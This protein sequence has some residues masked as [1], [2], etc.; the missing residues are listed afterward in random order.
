MPLPD[1]Q[2][3]DRRFE[4]LVADAQRRIPGYTP[5]WT[6]FNPSDPGITLVQLFAWLEEMILW[7]LNR[8]PEKNFIKFLELID[9]EL[10]PPAPATAELTFKLSTPDPPAPGYV[11][12]PQGTKISPSEQGEGGPIIFETDDNLYAVGATPPA[13]QSFDGAQCQLL[14]EPN[15][16]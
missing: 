14:T 6:D 4:D 11:L 15:R 13:L 9:I 10:N 8:V 16:F 7:R 3:D 12:I 5:E 2:L 1:I